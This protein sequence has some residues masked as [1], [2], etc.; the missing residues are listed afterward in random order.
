MAGLAGA[1]SVDLVP[2]A[3]AQGSTVPLS[4]LD[5]EP[6]NVVDGRLWALHMAISETN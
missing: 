6:I 3:F 5:P 2:E 4:G 1:I